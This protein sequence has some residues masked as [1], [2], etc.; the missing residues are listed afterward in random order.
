MH[1]TTLPLVFVSVV[2]YFLVKV[3]RGCAYPFVWVG[4]YL[5]A[6]DREPRFQKYREWC[7]NQLPAYIEYRGNWTVMIHT[8]KGKGW[9]TSVA[10]RIPDRVYRYWH[11]YSLVSMV[12]LLSVWSL[13][14]LFGV[15]VSIG[16][17][18]HTLTEMVPK[19][20]TVD[21]STFIQFGN[22]PTPEYELTLQTVLNGL[23]KV[24]VGLIQLTALLLLATLLLWVFMLPIIPGLIIHEFGHFASMQQ[25]GSDVETYGLIL[26]GPILAGAF[27]QPDESFEDVSPQKRLH[28]LSAGVGNT[29]LWATV[30][31]TGG[32]VLTSDPVSVL[33]S[34]AGRDHTVFIQHPVG[35][36][37]LLFGVFEM[38][39]AVGNAFPIGHVDGGLFMDAAEERW[40][41]L[42]QI[43]S[44]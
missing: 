21:W 4:Q 43:T 6:M 26:T 8:T 29:L 36:I 2:R 30:L 25:A 42:K 18:I 28:A 3:V 33:Q 12:V 17:Y 32:F 31:L 27:V 16:V 5:P 41:G 37:L 38:M 23:L 40:D 34:L 19:L 22:Q 13:A 15:G 9:F 1:A 7:V 44:E 11:R 10:A 14:I 39:N 20:L 24:G 35:S